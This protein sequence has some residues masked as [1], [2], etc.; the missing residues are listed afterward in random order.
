MSADRRIRR[1]PFNRG[2]PHIVW[3]KICV[4]ETRG[5][6][7][8]EENFPEVATQRSDQPIEDDQVDTLCHNW[9]AACS[10]NASYRWRPRYQTSGGNGLPIRG[11]TARLSSA[12]SP[13]RTT[14][15]A[16][17]HIPSLPVARTVE[18]QPRRSEVDGTQVDWQVQFVMEAARCHAPPGETLLSSRLGSGHVSFVTSR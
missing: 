15:P 8:A 2:L 3:W 5:A 4:G 13:N 1:F 9:P 7:R 17:H 14:S 10:E 16:G 11:M 12:H 18:R 6:V